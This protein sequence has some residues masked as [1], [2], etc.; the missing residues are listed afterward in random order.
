MSRA[1]IRKNDPNATPGFAIEIKD[2]TELGLAVGSAVYASFKATSVH[3][4]RKG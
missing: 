3:L 1:R 2:N 4:F